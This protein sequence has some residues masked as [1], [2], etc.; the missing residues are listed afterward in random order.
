MS[1]LGTAECQSFPPY[2][3]E[4]QCYTSAI[5]ANPD[6]NAHFGGAFPEMNSY[7]GMPVGSTPQLYGATPFQYGGIDPDSRFVAVNQWRKGAWRDSYEGGRGHK[8]GKKSGNFNHHQVHVQDVR[9]SN[10]Y[11]GSKKGKTNQLN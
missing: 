3:E 8:N 2:K 11:R 9:A 5:A 10:S 7:P 4:L 6:G 1:G